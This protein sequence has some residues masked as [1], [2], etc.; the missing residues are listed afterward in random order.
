MKDDNIKSI[1][2]LGYCKC[3]AIITKLELESKTIYNC[4]NCGKRSK[5]NK[6][7]KNNP[8]IKNRPKSKKEYL[9]STV[10]NIVPMN[11]SDIDPKDFKIA[12]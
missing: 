8:L 2:F 4:L 11:N 3:G 6:L 12:E 7:S 5:V 10:Q 1:K 9:E